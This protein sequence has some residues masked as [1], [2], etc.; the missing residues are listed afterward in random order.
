MNEN[1]EYFKLGFCI[2]VISGVFCTLLIA[3]LSIAT[4]NDEDDETTK[5]PCMCVVETE[6][7]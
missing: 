4:T 6:E 1:K 2:G 7:A 5:C 3:S